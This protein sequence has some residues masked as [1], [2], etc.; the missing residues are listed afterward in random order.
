[1][2]PA[3]VALSL[4]CA[5]PSTMRE[6]VVAAPPVP[7]VVPPG[8]SVAPDVAYLAS[9]ALRGRAAGSV[10]GDSA[11][12]YVARRFARLGLAGAFTAACKGQPPCSAAFYQY[13]KVL[14]GSA[15]NVVA[16]VPGTDSALADEYVVI[17]AHSDHIGTSTSM[18]NDVDRGEAIRPGA[19]DNASGTAALLELARRLAE[20]PPRRSVLLAAFD[21]EELGLLGSTEFLAHPPV[22]RQ[23][24]TLMVNLDMVGRLRGD[25]L[26]VEVHGPRTL[27]AL[28]DSSARAAGLRPSP[29][30]QT[31][32]RSDHATFVDWHIPAVALFTGF[33]DDYHRATDVPARVNYPGIRRVA[34]VAERIVR[35]VADEEPGTG[36]G[37]E[38]RR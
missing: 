5:R 16:L 26:Y 11:S 3:L 33:H 38:R 23:R 27:S 28:V 8:D 31:S 7:E 21:G 30:K 25:R 36:I 34:D 14:G 32:G 4:A 12:A 22:E 19:D 2:M 15:Q 13:F 24:M 20:R 18:A 17:G 10:G 9:R 29:T 35:A 6:V 37:R 1:M